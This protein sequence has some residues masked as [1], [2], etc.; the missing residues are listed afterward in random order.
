MPQSTLEYTSNISDTEDFT[1]AIISLHK[2]LEFHC[3]VNI[4][5]CKTRIN[6]IDNFLVGNGNP[7]GKFMHLEVKLFERR[8]EEII[9]SLGNLLI[10]MLSNYTS[11]AQ[12][13]PELDI[14][15]HIIDIERDH[16]FKYL[17]EVK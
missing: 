16:Y 10:N 9:L 4:N 2:I 12:K 1:P 7:S 17:S 5:N 3:E 8:S 15:V 6:R 14:T 13:N 11:L